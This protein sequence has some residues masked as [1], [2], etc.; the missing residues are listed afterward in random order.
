[1]KSQLNK[2]ASGIVFTLMTAYIFVLGITCYLK[3][4]HF[5]YDDFDLAIHT[6]TLSSILQGSSQTSILGIPFLGNHMVLILYLI[7][8]LYLVFHTPV[9][10]LSLQTIAL[11]SGA[12]PIYQLARRELSDTWGVALAAAYLIYS[13][14][15]YLNLYE[16]HPIAFASAFILYAFWFWKENR[17]TLFSL[18]LLLAASC[19]ENIS[20]IAIGFGIF[21]LL[22][23]KRWWWSVAPLLFGIAYFVTVVLYIMPHL[24]DTVNF[25]TL[26]AHLGNNMPDVIKNIVTHPLNTLHIMTEPRKLSFINQLFLPLA[27]LPVLSPLSWI[28]VGLVVAQRLLSNRATEFV[29]IFHYQAEFIPFIFVSTIYAIRTLQKKSIRILQLLPIV[30]MA[31]FPLLGFLTSG[32]IPLIAHNCFPSKNQKPLIKAKQ[33]FVRQVPP[34][35]KIACTFEFLSPLSDHR[36]LHSMHLISS[37]HYT[38]SPKPY[39][40]PTDLDIIAIDTNDRMTF[41]PN[42]FYTPT[43]YR[44]MQKL[45][46]NGTWKISSMQESF[47]ALEKSPT[48]DPLLPL[49]RPV[50]TIPATAFTNITQSGQADFTLQAFEITPQNGK[51]ESTLKL[52][53]KTPAT[54]VTD[55]DMLLTINAP[56]KAIYQVILSPGSRFWPPQSWPTNCIISDLHYIPYKASSPDT[57]LS[58]KMLPMTWQRGL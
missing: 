11:A 36:V 6:Q 4:H 52:Y 19:Q 43:V 34:N 28:P 58:V 20:F 38:L 54:V 7:A 31:C 13:P 8:P 29:I 3:Y 15:I 5:G 46:K 35:A 44:R 49:A 40:I 42:A 21:A 2:T 9:L 22:E 37:G 10:L 12:W 25:M 57:T 32:T 1:M 56:G 27:Y 14:L 33:K 50:A 51:T 23:R 18:M 24:N 16:F 55:A 45:L 53:W 39:P 26:Y 17:F 30:A 41:S 48:P 47:L